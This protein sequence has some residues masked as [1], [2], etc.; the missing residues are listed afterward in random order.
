MRPSHPKLSIQTQHCGFTLLEVMIAMT[1][2]VLAL[3]S[4][5]DLVNNY[6]GNT[7]YL[8]DKLV[9]EWVAKNRI[10]QSKL[11]SNFPATGTTSGESEMAGRTWVWTQTVSETGT[12][13][14]RK[15]DITVAIKGK[16][17]SISNLFYYTSNVFKPCEWKSSRQVTCHAQKQ[18]PG[19]KP[20]S[21]LESIGVR[22]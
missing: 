13:G 11:E 22:G 14:F 4:L 1:I 15:V 9:A 2:V 17:N 6:T 19:A 5:I 10:N 20:A 16:K 8:Q 18:R 3:M 7:A 12:K 21:P